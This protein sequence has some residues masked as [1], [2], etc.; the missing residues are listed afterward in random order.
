M[1][2]S[3][4]KAFLC[5]ASILFGSLSAAGLD[6][7]P[8]IMHIIPKCGTHFASKTMKL[9]AQK[10]VNYVGNY[11]YKVKTFNHK[12]YTPRFFEAFDA[13]L[14]QNWLSQNMKI[15]AIFRDPR[16]A[17]I[18]HLF[19]MRS[20]ARKNNVKPLRDFFTV[21]EGFDDLSFDDQLTALIT[22]LDD[23]ESYLEFY[24]DRILWSFSP[25]ALGVKYE[26]LLGENGNGTKELRKN[27]LIA[28][29]NFINLE[30]T[31]S[32]LDTV[33]K[34]MYFQDKNLVQDQ[35]VF[36]RATTGNWKKFMKP[37]HKQLFKERMG[38]LLV[39]LGY[40]ENNDW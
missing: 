9:L 16:D 35:K 19:Y 12:I 1:L 6:H 17:L 4:L 32:R 5:V 40:E 15:I 18:S 23:M 26:D 14:E 30:L 2:I 8:F 3:K 11:I 29:A 25:G 20:F 21:C 28:I 33:L 24:K 13:E 10:R 38:N 36:V 37:K 22:G 31:E 27:T 34:H 7:D 39:D